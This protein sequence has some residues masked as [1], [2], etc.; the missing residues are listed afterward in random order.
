MS[1]SSKQFH[2]LDITMV[3]DV[4]Q[5]LRDYSLPREKC[6]VRD[7]TWEM[8]RDLVWPIHTIEKEN[9]SM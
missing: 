3:W 5:L 8:Q 7:T 6:H 1:P 4:Y 2:V 9:L